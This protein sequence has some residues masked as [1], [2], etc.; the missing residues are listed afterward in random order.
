MEL[1]ESIEKL[2]Y[3]KQDAKAKQ[4]LKSKVDEIKNKSE[5]ENKK[6]E[7]LVLLGKEI[8][9]VNNKL[10]EV[11][12]NIDELPYPNQPALKKGAEISAKDKFKEKLNNLTN[13]KDIENVLPSNWKNNITMYNEVFKLIKDLIK[14]G[15]RTNLIKR[16]IQTD[17]SS[18]GNFT[19]AELI[20][21]IYETVRIE[22][23]PKNNTVEKLNNKQKHGKNVKWLL[24]N[25]KKLKEVFNSEKKKPENDTNME[26]KNN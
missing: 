15:K 18:T 8:E 24:D 13:I 21:Q 12:K 17:N 5:K 7:E 9:Q 2:P 16:F 26:K 11:I 23:L 19:E 20:W 6:I 14:E 10:V 25:I 4:T 3:P 1:L 22:I